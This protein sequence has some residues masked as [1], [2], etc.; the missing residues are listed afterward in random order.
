VS[1]LSWWCAVLIGF[2]HRHVESFI[3][4]PDAPWLVCGLTLAALL[5]LWAGGEAVLR[6]M[7]QA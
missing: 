1:Q 3:W 7:T 2:L 5:L 4:W 6:K